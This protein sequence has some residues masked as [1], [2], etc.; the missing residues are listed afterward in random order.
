MDDIVPTASRSSSS[1]ARGSLE[2]SDV[3]EGEGEEDEGHTHDQINTSQIPDAPQP[4]QQQRQFNFKKRKPREYSE[5]DIYT[6]DAYARKARKDPVIEA[7]GESEEEEPL[8]HLGRRRRG[9]A[10]RKEVVGKTKG[11]RGKN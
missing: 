4:S 1:V 5:H 10:K 7:D 6:P 2:D 11:G 3:G 9:L 8:P